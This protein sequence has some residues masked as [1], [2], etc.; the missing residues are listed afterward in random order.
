MNNN[1]QLST[2]SSDALSP[3]D[4]PNNGTTH[5]HTSD[6]NPVT[7]ESLSSIEMEL[8]VHRLL[9]RLEES[10]TKLRDLEQRFLDHAMIKF[11]LAANATIAKAQYVLM[12]VAQ[13]YSCKPEV[14][15]SHCRSAPLVAVRHKAIWAIKQI[16]D[17]SNNE[18]SAIV[19][20]DHS[21]IAY[22]IKCVDDR[23]G[24]DKKYRLELN[25]M[26]SKLK[27]VLRNE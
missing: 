27:E 19:R 4:P 26:L 23:A 6:A 2:V 8:L 21:G 16:T 22:A 7:V 18:I 9:H 3:N 25:E 11:P 10:E 13:H 12:F 15:L 17:L 14:L 24:I 1:L 20:R 5:R